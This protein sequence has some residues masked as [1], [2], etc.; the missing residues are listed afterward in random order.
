MIIA[1]SEIDNLM[2]A[3][4]T[5]GALE[6]LDFAPD[7]GE[8]VEIAWLGPFLAVVIAP[9]TEEV[10]F[11]GLILRGLLGRWRPAAAI[12]FS[13]A[14][15]AL[16]HFNPAQAPVALL[17]GLL[18]GWLYDLAGCYSTFYDSLPVLKAEG[19]ERDSRLALC[20]LTGRVLRRGL[21][22]LGIGTVEKM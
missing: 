15:F 16:V 10:V 11:R 4:L 1:L 13:S 22:L 14:L 19:P 20:D 17:L 6:R 21:D 12:L 18:T 9:V 5:P 2:R 8:I 7:L 3:A